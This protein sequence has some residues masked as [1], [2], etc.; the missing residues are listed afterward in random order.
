MLVLLEREDWP[1]V[2]CAGREFGFVPRID[3]ALDFAQTSRVLLVLHQPS[4]ISVD[5]ILGALSLEEEI[6]H[7]ATKVEIAGVTVPLPAPSRSWS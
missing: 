1:G 4:G 7:G 3:D 5:I 6:V 2:S